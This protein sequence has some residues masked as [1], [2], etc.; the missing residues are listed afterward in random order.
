MLCVFQCLSGTAPAAAAVCC[1]CCIACLDVLLAQCVWFRTTE[2]ASKWSFCS[3]IW[4]YPGQLPAWAKVAHWHWQCLYIGPH[5][6]TVS[7]TVLG[8]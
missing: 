3:S 8:A 1:R 7:P 6:G 5:F 4:V 2:C